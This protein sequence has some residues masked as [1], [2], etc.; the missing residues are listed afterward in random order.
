MF[1][2]KHSYSTVF[3]FISKWPSMCL[4]YHSDHPW[5]SDCPHLSSILSVESSLS[6]TCCKCR[7]L[8]NDSLNTPSFLSYESLLLFQS[9]QLEPPPPAL[10]FHLFRLIVQ[11]SPISCIIGLRYLVHLLYLLA[12]NQ[13]QLI[14][15]Q[16]YRVP[17]I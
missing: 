9:H 1:K 13:E 14:Y 2:G 16:F 8:L 5:S 11:L 6:K 7:F 17:L 15:V 10:S 4:F 3:F 12:S